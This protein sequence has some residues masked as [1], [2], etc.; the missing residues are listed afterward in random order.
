MKNLD[1][2]HYSVFP[3]V[4]EETKISVKYE[5]PNLSP[6]VSPITLKDLESSSLELPKHYN[7]GDILV[8]HPYMPNKL[9]D[10]KTAQTDI[11]NERLA[12]I[13]TILNYLGAKEITMTA[14]IK[15][16]EY[17]QVSGKGKMSMRIFSLK[18]RF[19]LKKQQ[20]DYTHIQKHIKGA[21]IWDNDS[22]NK[23]KAYAKEKGL[24]QD[25][26]IEELIMERDPK[27]GIKHY[28]LNV[29]IS[30]EFNEL[31]DAAATL[32]VKSDTGINLFHIEG[33]IKSYYEHKD[34]LIV[35]QSID[36]I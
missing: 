16:R 25:S 14:T 1:V 23:A 24:I 12:H 22:Y 29:E 5:T 28:M 19:F 34:T 35:K 3:I 7:I 31:M 32:D 9:I 10:I 33:S 13:A 4:N 21:E 11:L 30:K 27:Q 26:N 6:K 20:N 36:F 18:G 15:K 8:C 2:T 17:R